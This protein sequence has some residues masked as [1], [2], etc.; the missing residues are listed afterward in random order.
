MD[1]FTERLME[2]S[3]ARQTRLDATKN[4]TDLEQSPLKENNRN[5]VTT[6][7]SV[8]ISKGANNRNTVTIETT[9]TMKRIPSKGSMNK[10][11]E[12]KTEVVQE[13]TTSYDEESETDYETLTKENMSPSH[14]SATTNQ[15]QSCGIRQNVKSQ[16]KRLG[17]LYSDGD[18]NLSSPIHRTEENFVVDNKYK[19]VEKHERKNIESMPRTKTARSARLAALANTINQW[20]DDL[21]HPNIKPEEDSLGNAVPSNSP[22]K[23][24]PKS[25]GKEIQSVTRFGSPSQANPTMGIKQLRSPRKP[26]SPAVGSVLDKAAQYEE[27]TSATK[28]TVDPAELPLSERLALFEKNKGNAILPKAPF[29]TSVPIKHERYVDKR[30]PGNK[31]NSRYPEYMGYQQPAEKPCENDFAP[32]VVSKGLQSRLAMFEQ[33]S[34]QMGEKDHMKDILTERQRELEALKSRWNRPQENDSAKSCSPAPPPPPMPPS[35]PKYEP[36]RS[37][38]YYESDEEEDENKTSEVA[39]SYSKLPEKSYP[40]LCV[41]PVKISPPKPGRLYPSLSDMDTESEVPES[42]DCQRRNCDRI[43]YEEEELS[44]DDSL[45]SF[46]QKI[47]EVAQRNSASTLKRDLDDGANAGNDD[48]NEMDDFLDEALTTLSSEDDATP[49]KRSMT[50]SNY[51]TK[52]SVSFEYTQGDGTSENANRTPLVHTISVYRKQQALSTKPVSPPRRVQIDPSQYSIDSDNAN[53]TLELERELEMI[54]QKIE[55]LEQEVTKQSII[56][57]QSS[58]ALNLCYSTIEFSGS[59]EQVE[60]ERHLLVATIKRQAASHEIQRL[61][62]ECSLRPIGPNNKMLTERGSVTISQITLPLKLDIIRSAARDEQCYYLVCLIR[63]GEKVLATNMMSTSPR[64][65]RDNNRLTFPNTLTLNNLY[66]D[67]KITVEVY[68]MASRS[69]EVIPHDI[70]YHIGTNK[71]EASKLM[72]LTPKKNKA[73]S[74][75]IMPV[76][77]SPGG[78]NAVRTS[79]FN[80]IGYV[81][82]SLREIQR[83]QFTLNKVAYTSVIEGSLQLKLDCEMTVDIEHRGFLTMFED[84]S[85]FGA[86]HRR[87]CLL[88]GDQLSYWKYP[89]DERKKI[90][91]DTIE[92]SACVTEVI[93]PVSRDVCARPN[94][95]LLETAR[96]AKR[97][98]VDSLVLVRNGDRTVIRHLLSADTKE[99][100]I[101]W[102]TQLNKALALMQAWGKKFPS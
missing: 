92:L 82:F 32:P 58:Q 3:R 19:E 21:S 18:P 1:S 48:R 49:P 14:T 75:L 78:P 60:A 99:E 57:Q 34:S 53:D 25:P 43:I 81:I 54:D 4:K 42:D 76:V 24:K 15:G 102:C 98:D 56:I 63:C 89:D 66:S 61:K 12:K 90:A 33:T 23:T 30:Q 11:F 7:T 79:A 47:K 36:R 87:W 74:R 88:K 96:P 100:R 41:K 86:W 52:A 51:G 80:M 62:I 27:S 55:E 77:Q 26:A 64:S 85:G 10:S 71:K 45:S 101:Q 72:R 29:A 94:T 22:G 67:F 13:D 95:F 59:T 31:I 69:K 46:G 6:S 28:K 35:P 2:R 9:V 16:L 5:K 91:I 73:E 44:S 84:I 17:Q 38:F 40:G 83:T 93:G 65:F 8:G 97:E 70:K 39:V 68:A 37:N 50:T 20:E